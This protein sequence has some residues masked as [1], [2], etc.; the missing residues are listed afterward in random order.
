M[1]NM[2]T[3]SFQFI[4]HLYSTICVKPPPYRSYSGICDNYKVLRYSSRVR[5]RGGRWSVLSLPVE[6]YHVA[7]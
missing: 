6:S 1:D 2:T 4:L 5:W 7:E 3:E